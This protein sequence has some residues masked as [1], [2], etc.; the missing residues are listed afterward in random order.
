DAFIETIEN[1]VDYALSTPDPDAY[2]SRRMSDADNLAELKRMFAEKH[3]ALAENLQR[4]AE[5]ARELKAEKFVSACGV[6]YEV[7]SCRQSADAVP[8]TSVSAKADVA[9][10][11]FNEEYKQ[12][13]TDCKT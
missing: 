4:L 7:I 5:W 10:I 12:V 6:L 2:L 9:L 1:I 13:K 3:A 8:K 11:A